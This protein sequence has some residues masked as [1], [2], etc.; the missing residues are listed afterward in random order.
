MNIT[1]IGMPG[2]GKT[3]LGI[4]LA[5]D[6]GMQFVDSDRVIEHQEGMKLA[7]I[8]ER[9][10]DDG[11]REVENRV[12]ASLQVENAVIAPGGSVIYGAEA[13]AHLRETSTGV[14]LRLRYETVKQRLGDLHA[15][16]VTFQPGQTLLDLYHERCPLYERYAH[17]VVDCD[18][19][20]PRICVTEIREKLKALQGGDE[21]HGSQDLPDTA[22]RK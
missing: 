7:E 4:F 14:Y 3:T 20:K 13:M 17:L 11:F 15:R 18:G 5:R 9:S 16:G 21:I 19:K 1:L 10:G 8:I 12:N 2:S 22:G 6:L